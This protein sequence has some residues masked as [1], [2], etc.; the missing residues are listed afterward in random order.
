[1]RILLTGASGF[2]GRNL[3]AALLA[4][5]HEVV[6]A[7]RSSGI[8]FRQMLTAD[9]WLPHLV[10]TDAVINSVG[11]IG[12]CGSQRFDVLHTHAPA[13][14]FRACEHAG[15]RRVLQ[16]SALGADDTAF[17]PYHL[18]KKAADDCLRSLD[19][20]WFVLRPSLIYGHGG[21][22][23]ELF[24]RLAALPMIPVVGD[25]QQMLQPVHIS[26]VV[27]TTMQALVTPESGQTLDIVGTE[28]ISFADWLQRMREVQGLR[29]AQF[30]Q[31]PFGLCMAS[32]RVGRY[33]N[34]ILQPDNLRMLKVG[35]R[36]DPKPV[37]RFLGRALLRSTPPL[38]FTDATPFGSTS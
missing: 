14:L 35:Y 36:A 37:E 9:D 38:F 26:D 3:R 13:A 24:M 32:A 8:D 17:S 21:K 29:P 10:G 19:L 15:V 27:A 5:G 23:A 31:V 12:E 11:I 6:A 33:L 20:D 22:S 18:S 1:M 2:I 34:P 4:A 30:L 16:I 7:S 28:I 25:G